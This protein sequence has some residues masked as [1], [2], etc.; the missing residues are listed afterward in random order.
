MTRRKDRFSLDLTFCLGDSLFSGQCLAKVERLLQHEAQPWTSELGIW[1]EHERKRS[2]V[3]SF[4]VDVEKAATE[5]GALYERLIRENI[6]GPHA[7]RSGSVELRGADETL[8]VVLALDDYLFAPSAGRWLW[9]NTVTIQI[10]EALSRSNFAVDFAR[11]FAA[12]A[13]SELSPWY[14]HGHLREEWDQ[15]NIS[16]EGG[17]VMAVGLDVSRYLPGVY[18]LN[19]FGEPYCN[20][21]GK[22]RLLHAPVGEARAVDAGVL[23]F[24]SPTP[25]AWDTPEYRAAETLIQAHLGDLYFF[26]RRETGRNTLAPDFGLKVLPRHARFS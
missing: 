8:T 19:F 16:R 13:C 22:D 6:T 25:D 23:L 3:R 5:H 20:L 17:G 1:R 14:A 4:V 12:A 2:S 9:G 26:S 21:I 15:K 10:R 7:R 11:R 24:L 18:W